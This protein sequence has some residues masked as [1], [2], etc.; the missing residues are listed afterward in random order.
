MTA[1]NDDSQLP[2]TLHERGVS[3]KPT[4]YDKLMSSPQWK[5]AKNRADPETGKIYSEQERMEGGLYIVRHLWSDAN[6]NELRKRLGD[7]TPVFIIMPSTTGQNS[8][9]EALGWFLQNEIGGELLSGDD[10]ANAVHTRAMKDVPAEDRPFVAREYIINDPEGLRRRV[11]GKA[12]VV[13][14][15]VFSSGASAKSFCDTLSECTIQVTTVA[16]LLG[17]SRLTA[18]PQMVQK[19][20]KTLK[21]AGLDFKA[22]DIAKV[23]SRGQVNTLIDVINIRG[24]DEREGIAG[25]I[26]R[27]LDSRVARHLGQDSWRK[28]DGGIGRSARKSSGRSEDGAGIRTQSDSENRGGYNALLDGK[29]TDELKRRQIDENRRDILKRLDEREARKRA[30]RDKGKDI[31]R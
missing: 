2:L 21:H 9:P 16:G 18:E 11:A 14:E 7:K 1:N 4:A 10:V 5:A 24:K 31:G 19:L 20:S 6:T 15:D 12:V 26:Q 27:I 30:E 13:V 3:G 23:L 17:D 22:K 28:A 8:L 25:G 29:S